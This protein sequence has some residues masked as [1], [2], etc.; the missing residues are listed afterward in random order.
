MMP[1]PY[2]RIYISFEHSDEVIE[3][4]KAAFDIAA[5]QLKGQYAEV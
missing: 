5:R 1:S 4:M 2:G 3:E